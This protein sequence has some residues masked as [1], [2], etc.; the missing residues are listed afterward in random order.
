MTQLVECVLCKHEVIGSSPIISIIYFE[1]IVISKT[2]VSLQ[3][4]I[5]PTSWWLTATR[6]TAE[7][8]K[9]KKLAFFDTRNHRI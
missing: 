9:K 5:E 4:G 1:I 6:S 7:L 3:A 8:L 2:I